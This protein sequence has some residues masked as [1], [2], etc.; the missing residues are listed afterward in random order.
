MAFADVIVS[1]FLVIII[2]PVLIIG[3]HKISTDSR[4]ATFKLALDNGAQSQ[5]MSL[6]DALL[7]AA[8]LVKQTKEADVDEGM[9]SLRTANENGWTYSIPDMYV[10]SADEPISLDRVASGKLASA[11]LTFL[12]EKGDLNVDDTA[13]AI[14]EILRTEPSFSDVELIES[15]RE[16]FG[17]SIYTINLKGRST[18]SK[19]SFA[20]DYSYLMSEVNFF[21]SDFSKLLSLGSKVF[22]ENE[23]MWIGQV[24]GASENMQG[25]IVVKCDDRKPETVERD[26]FVADAA[27]KCTNGVAFA[28]SSLS[29]IAGLLSYKFSSITQIPIL[30]TALSS[31]FL[32][33]LI[34]LCIILWISLPYVKM[35]VVQYS[36]DGATV[37][38]ENV[39]TITFLSFYVVALPVV[40]LIWTFG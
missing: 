21:N 32:T 12:M 29:G 34:Y 22:S 27:S 28:A 7:M 37:F 16:P 2:L 10:A 18:P 26:A 33:V 24:N 39:F 13:N 30:P 1:L 15:Y 5:Q 11:G 40:Y 36:A 35:L 9:K 23:L 20:R 38:E 14:V 31:I 6:R 17:R 19:L 8:P 4:P 3:S 25:R